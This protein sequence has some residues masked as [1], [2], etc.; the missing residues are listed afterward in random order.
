MSNDLWSHVGG[1]VEGQQIWATKLWCDVLLI[2]VW[3]R[4]A[5]LSGLSALFL[6]RLG[7]GDEQR[8]PFRAST[9]EEATWTDSKDLKGSQRMWGICPTSDNFGS[10]RSTLWQFLKIWT[11]LMFRDVSRCFEMF[12]DVS[13]NVTNHANVWG[14]RSLSFTSHSSNQRGEYRQVRS[15]WTFRR[16]LPSAMQQHGLVRH[17]DGLA[18]SERQGIPG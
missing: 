11:C 16:L 7:E 9:G 17:E 6:L 12:R 10:T 5:R 13:S 3:H 1:M 4:G 8:V 14:L 15:S 18:C 2:S